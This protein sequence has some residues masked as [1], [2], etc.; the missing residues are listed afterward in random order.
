[1][2]EVHYQLHKRC[3]L[4]KKVETRFEQKEEEPTK[5]EKEL[6]SQTVKYQIEENKAK[7]TQREIKHIQALLKIMQTQQQKGKMMKSS[8]QSKFQRY[9]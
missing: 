5:S 6:Q 8:V 2:S 3:K 9:E 1:M 4:L 7:K